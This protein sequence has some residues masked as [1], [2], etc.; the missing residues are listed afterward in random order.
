MAGGTVSKGR[1][2]VTIC[3]N[4]SS[5]KWSNDQ[6]RHPDPDGG[7]VPRVRLYGRA[8]LVR[9]DGRRFRRDSV[10]PSQPAVDGRTALPR[11]RFR[12]AARGPVFLLVGELMASSD[13]VARM[14]PL[15]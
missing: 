9:V 12:N 10:Y 3:R 2:T 7:A 15:L 1:R 11:H 5:R 14:I 13:V 8:G 4:S 6:R